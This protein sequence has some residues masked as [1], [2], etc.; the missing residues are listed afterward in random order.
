MNFHKK[1]N[2]A[3]QCCITKRNIFLLFLE[4]HL[5]HLNILWYHIYIMFGYIH[6]N[7]T[8]AYFLQVD[9]F[10]CQFLVSTD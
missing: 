7:V 1:N 4:Y 6:V 9:V 2:A 10:F 8:V 5:Y 3:I